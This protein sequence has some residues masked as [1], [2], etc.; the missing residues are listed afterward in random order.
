MGQYVS[1]ALAGLTD[2]GRA[3]LSPLSGLFLLSH[4][5]MG[6]SQEDK[7]WCGWPGL[8]LRGTLI[9]TEASGHT[10]VSHCTHTQPTHYTGEISA[11]YKQKLTI[12]QQTPP[13]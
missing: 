9:R 13:R 12:L 2:V 11:P 7:S 10:G 4:V 8:A 6:G 3:A 1:G 5:T